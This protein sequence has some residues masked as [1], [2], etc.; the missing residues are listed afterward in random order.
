[1]PLPPG[2]CLPQLNC[3]LST[4]GHIQ[5]SSSDRSYEQMVLCKKPHACHKCFIISLTVTAAA[6][7]VV[8]VNLWRRLEHK[9]FRWKPVSVCR[10]DWHMGL[11]SLCGFLLMHKPDS[12]K[13]VQTRL[14]QYLGFSSQREQGGLKLIIGLSSQI[15]Q[16]AASS[17]G[18][19]R[20]D[21]HSSKTW[22]AL[23]PILLVMKRK[24]SQG[25]GDG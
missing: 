11:S 25:V 9:R 5:I 1:M 14:R 19:E 17:F 7:L 18:V 3:W 13:A 22:Q 6:A 4:K 10:C 20:G 21:K 23:L 2:L 24:P 12:G 8:L 16:I 15:W